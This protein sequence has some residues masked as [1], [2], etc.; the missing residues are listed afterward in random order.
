MDVD[1][2]TTL[3]A[4]V[5]MLR[6]GASSVGGG[7]AQPTFSVSIQQTE[8][9]SA[10]ATA[11]HDTTQ[12]DDPFSRMGIFLVAGGEWWLCVR[13][14][15]LQSGRC[16]PAQMT[17]LS[18]VAGRSALACERCAV[19]CRAVLSRCRPCWC[20]EPHCHSPGRPP[21]DA[22]AGAGGAPDVDTRGAGHDV[23][24]RWA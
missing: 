2:R 1:A 3:S 23:L 17:D 24:R 4:T 14:P 8:A 7:P 18:A 11:E 10:G 16:L 6:H 21:E 19:P 20:S 12:E 22:A 13:L 15:A 9:V 5:A